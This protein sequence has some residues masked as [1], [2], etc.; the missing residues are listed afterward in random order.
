MLQVWGLRWPPRW[1]GDQVQATRWPRFRWR[2]HCCS[3]Q[4]RSK[5]CAPV[6]NLSSDSSPQLTW[7]QLSSDFFCFLFF[8]LSPNLASTSWLI[9]LFL[10]GRPNSELD[11][12]RSSSG[13]WP[14]PPAE[15]R[16]SAK[17]W[18]REF[19]K[20]FQERNLTIGR[21]RLRWQLVISLI[22]NAFADGANYDSGWLMNP[23]VLAMAAMTVIAMTMMIDVMTY[24]CPYVYLSSVGAQ[25]FSSVSFGITERRKWVLRSVFKATLRSTWAV[26]LVRVSQYLRNQGS[27]T[28]WQNFP[29]TSS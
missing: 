17:N 21:C 5:T 14:S 6:A 18:K 10:G 16:R 12:V 13:D 11:L 25:V 20:T 22:V 19:W 23:P 26:M 1:P 28:H 9:F 15:R 8:F 2:P 3:P 4:V 27:A 7:G 24:L 29:Q